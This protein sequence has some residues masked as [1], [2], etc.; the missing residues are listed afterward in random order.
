MVTMRRDRAVAALPQAS[1]ATSGA[2]ASTK[3]Y[4]TNCAATTVVRVRLEV[5]RRVRDLVRG[6][7]LVLR[8]PGWTTALPTTATV[9][10]GRGEPAVSGR[11]APRLGLEHWLR[12]DVELNLGN[13]QRLDEVRAAPGTARPS[14]SARRLAAKSARRWS[15]GFGGTVSRSA[16]HGSGSAPG[17]RWIAA[18]TTGCWTDLR[19]PRRR[20]SARCRYYLAFGVGAGRCGGQRTGAPWPSP[21]APWVWGDEVEDLV[22]AG[23]YHLV[24]SRDK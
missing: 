16:R 6:D 13:D 23:A 9:A 15:W 11:R 1:T 20:P 7:Y 12:D 3:T 10:D 19:S 4:A 17:R 24:S 21:S 18:V 5:R 14:A 8:V 2:T 22:A